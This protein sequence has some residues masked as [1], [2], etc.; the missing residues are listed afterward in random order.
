MIIFGLGNR[1]DKYEHTRHNAGHKLVHK[2][3]EKLNL[4]PLVPHKKTQTYQTKKDDLI[5]A[6]ND[7][8]MNESGLPLRQLVDYYGPV[9][10]AVQDDNNK[11][12]VVFDDL[13]IKFGEYKIQF[14]KG[15]KDHNGLN[16]V[17]QH[18]GSDQFWHVRIGVD[19]R[20]QDNRMPGENYV[21]M[22]MSEE[23]EEKLKIVISDVILNLIQNLKWLTN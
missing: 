9:P 19:S 5:L 7:S 20:P 17:Y 21:L 13:D 15:P 16:S 22:R 8:Y 3:A 4:P 6:I 10:G 1:D 18:L 23:E 14:G 2:L 12:L 11:L